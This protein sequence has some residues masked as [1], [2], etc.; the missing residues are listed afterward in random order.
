MTFIDIGV[1]LMHRGFSS[2]RELVAHRAAEAGVAPLIITGT[3][4]S[5][6]RAAACYA[7]QSPGM[8][9]ATAGVH[10]HEAKNC[11]PQTLDALA[12]LARQD[13]VL[14]IGECGLDYN[15]DFSPREIQTLW[16][17]KQLELAA[18]L[19]LPVFLHERDAAGDF[20]AIL[21]NH[22][23][24]LKAVVVHCFTGG[25][26]ELDAYLGLGCSIG[27][28]GWVCDE[29]RGRHLGELLEIIPAGRLMLET[30]APF[31]LPRDLPEKACGA[32]SGRNEPCFLPHIARAVAR[33]RGE[34]PETIAAQTTA[35][36][37]EFFGISFPA[38]TIA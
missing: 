4:E 19:S 20:T 31:L 11:G 38:A 25:R 3:S 6:S 23:R 28:T 36:A 29:R 15:R 9:Y 7:A 22:I 24:G 14:A 37:R 27:V 10:P 34:D 5:S 35:N 26:K 2:D 13:C 32:R 1:N 8:L 18:S 21:K 33:H 17:E 16:F 30:D 12:G